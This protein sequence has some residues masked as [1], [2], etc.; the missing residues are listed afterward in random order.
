MTTLISL[1]ENEVMLEVEQRLEANE[2]SKNRKITNLTTK[3]THQDLLKGELKAAVCEANELATSGNYAM[4]SSF[5]TRAILACSCSEEEMVSSL[6]V[7]RA[8]CLARCDISFGC[9]QL[10]VVYLIHFLRLDNVKLLCLCIVAVGSQD[11]SPRGGCSRSQCCC[12][13]DETK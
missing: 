4:A 12:G 1:C 13:D 8:T 5:Y 2:V 7:K 9:V 3:N 10:K 11:W 6:F